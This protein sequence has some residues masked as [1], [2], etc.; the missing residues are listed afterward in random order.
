MNLCEI[1]EPTC[2]KMRISIEIKGSTSVTH[3]FSIEDEGI[4]E[5]INHV[6]K[7]DSPGKSQKLTN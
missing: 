6:A 7:S 4:T 3:T 2:A 1:P 5:F